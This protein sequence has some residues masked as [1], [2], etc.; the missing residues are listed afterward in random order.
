MVEP[1][2]EL[3]IRENTAW[4]CQ[5]GL[6]RWATGCSCTPGD[7]SWKGA[8][9][10]AMDNARHHID[11]TYAHF[12]EKLPG[13]VDMYALRDAYIDVVLDQVKP[14]D[15]IVGQGLD[16]PKDTSSNLLKLVESQFYRQRMYSSC[17]FFFPELTA[18]TT[19]YGIANAA[20]AIKLTSEVSGESV[21]REFRQDL[22]VATSSL[23]DGTPIT[24]ADLY[25]QV[26][27][28]M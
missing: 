27:Q 14:K 3:S 10:R 6:K 13:E 8:V 22:S 20:F 2:G 4:S 9:R 19:L 16:L 21:G 11:D 1:V 25:D 28:M 26:L 15:F 17:T 7:S 5:H 18:L 12:V 24:G 23:D